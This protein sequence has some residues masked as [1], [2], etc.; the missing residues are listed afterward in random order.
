LVV[1]IAGQPNGEAA[2][3]K[4]PSVLPVK[5]RLEMCICLP[6]EFERWVALPSW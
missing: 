4:A 2:I 1:A 5:R 6:L 3:A